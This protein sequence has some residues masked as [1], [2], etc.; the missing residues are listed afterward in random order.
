MDEQR[1]L[2]SHLAVECAAMVSGA[3]AWSGEAIKQ[4][5]RWRTS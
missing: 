3:M 5:H 2:N 4:R 1:R